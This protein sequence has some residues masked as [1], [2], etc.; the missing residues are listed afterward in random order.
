MKLK[1]MAV[2]AVGASLAFAF[3]YGAVANAWPFFGR[4]EYYGYFLNNNDPYGTNVWPADSDTA[5][6]AAA[7][8]NALPNSIDNA[9]E[10][11]NFVKCKLNSNNSS[12]TYRNAE[13]TG[14]AFII[15][16]MIGLNTTRPPTAAQIAEW[17]ARVNYASMMGWITWNTTFSYSINSYW[18]GTGSGGNYNDDALYDNAGSGAAI[19]FRNAGG[20]IIYAIRKQCANPVGNAN[21]APLP[22]NPDFNMS[23]VSR[24]SSP[25]VPEA[26]NIT[27]AAGSTV[28]FRHT[29]T[30]S[31]ATSPVTIDWGTYSQTNTLNNSGNA[32]SFT[33]GQSKDVGG[34][35]INNIAAGVHCRYVR[36]DPDTSAGGAESSSMACVTAVADYD[37]NPSINI[38]INGG[39]TPG[40]YAE[41]GDTVTFTYAVNNTDTN[42]SPSTPCY[43]YGLSRDGHYTIPNPIDTVSDA[44]YAP[45]AGVPGCPRVFPGSSTTTLGSENVTAVLNKSIC[46]SLVVDPATPAGGARG[47]EVCAYVASKPYARTYGGDVSAG[48]GL[49]SSPGSCSLDNDA[50]II[51]WNKR[52][53]GSWAG[54]GVQFAAY[55]MR[56][57]FDTTTS[58]GNG[59][60]SAPVP[61][62]LAFSNVGAATFNGIVGVSLGSVDCVDDYYATKPSTTSSI[63]ASVAAMTSGSYSG[64]GNIQL[65]GGNIINPNNRIS[66][67]VDGNVFI[68]NNIV[69]AGT[70]DV[71]TMP[72]FRLIVRGN[73]YID[74]DVAQLDGLYVA[75]PNGATGGNIYT[76]ALAADP[77]NP[78]LPTH[79]SFLTQCDN[80]KLTVNGA[81]V[82]KQVQLLRTIG[83]LRSSNATEAAS[84]G[85][86]AEVF[87]YSPAMWIPQPSSSSGTPEYDAISSLP[88]VL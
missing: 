85:S 58:I 39:A 73:I 19:V 23:G 88:P 28:T 6:C 38:Q 49:A 72:M 56:T 42:A 46:R 84:S 64:T 12:T 48:G 86:I 25:G 35:V 2:L 71:G 5:G 74:N 27:V 22:N 3:G 59:A 60:G 61:S 66:V 76:C 55:A 52:S 29:L 75:Q 80:N 83:T 17:E 20:T 68:S 57:I 70:W 79:S 13:R 9:T 18:Q 7:S 15:Q 26:Q 67:Y 24:V 47:V 54:A 37:L 43:I 78:M 30:S 10:L 32:G 44:G 40:N 62:G 11:I 53:A 82:A 8:G 4:N 81:F 1:K 65:G 50:S 41:P 16:T 51:G 87:N 33:A 14:A 21:T 36:W 34:Q 77:F 45:P 69:Y 63:P 31:G